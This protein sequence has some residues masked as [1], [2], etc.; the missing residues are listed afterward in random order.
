MNMY[1]C[2]GG[3]MNA[4]RARKGLIIAH[5]MPL[6]LFID[7][8]VT[9]LAP[10][11]DSSP[12]YPIIDYYGCLDYSTCYLKVIAA[13]QALDSMNKACSFISGNEWTRLEGEAGICSC[14]GTKNSE[15]TS[16]WQSGRWSKEVVSELIYFRKARKVGKSAY[17]SWLLYVKAKDV[18]LKVSSEIVKKVA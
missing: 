14:Y 9:T 4:W 2:M 18:E 17:Y 8:C 7:S 16:K 3:Y 12:S 15:L 13:A 6:L 11:K 1:V 5:H 10:D